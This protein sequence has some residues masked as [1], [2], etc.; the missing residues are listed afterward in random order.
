MKAHIVG[1]SRSQSGYYPVRVD[2]KVGD[3]ADYVLI[4]PGQDLRQRIKEQIASW[5]E[6][7]ASGFL[8]QLHP[9]VGQEID[10]GDE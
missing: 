7:E 9:L 3:H 4:R 2:F 6:K 10:L 8:L 5:S 1:V